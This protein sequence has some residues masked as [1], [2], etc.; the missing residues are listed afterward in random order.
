MVFI[1]DVSYSS[2][3]G[4]LASAAIGGAMNAKL[5]LW[6]NDLQKVAEVELDMVYCV[7]RRRSNGLNSA[8]MP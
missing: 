8:F 5:A 1:D 2:T 6:S 4:C 7:A 3:I